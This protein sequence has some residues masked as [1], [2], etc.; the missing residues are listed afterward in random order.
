MDERY[1]LDPDVAALAARGNAPIL[2]QSAQAQIV[3]VPRIVQGEFYFGGYRYSRLHINTK[4]L[5]M[6][7]RLVQ[8]PLYHSLACD[9]DTAQ[10]YG[11][12][13]ADLEAKGQPI[14]PNDIWIAALARQHRL[15]L[16]TRDGQYARVSRLTDELI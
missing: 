10:I 11:A 7:D 13:R 16:L 14:Q 3:Y 1:L 8:D 4:F 6:Y 5:D 9:L 12:I 15:T 2:R